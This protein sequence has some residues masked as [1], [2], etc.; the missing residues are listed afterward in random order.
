MRPLDKVIPVWY[1]FAVAKSRMTIK[2]QVTIPKEL[3]DA[4]GWA[5]GEEVTFVREADGVKLLAKKTARKPGDA[6]VA[7]LRGKGNR[8]MTTDKILALT[9]GDDEP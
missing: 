3:R 2:G 8:Q 9:R 4:F 6:L 5:P 1:Y 7:R